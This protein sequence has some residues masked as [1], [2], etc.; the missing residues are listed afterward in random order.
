MNKKG[1]MVRTIIKVLLI[2]FFCVVI[3]IIVKNYIGGMLG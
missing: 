2:I 3:S 1:I